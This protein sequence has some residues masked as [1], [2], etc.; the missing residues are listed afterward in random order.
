[1]QK[2]MTVGLLIFLLGLALIF[3]GA[4]TE[5]GFSAGGFILIGPFPIVFGAGPS[6]VTL[7][8][9]SIALGAAVLALVFLWSRR[10]FRGVS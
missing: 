6:G 3:L 5:G 4:A 7:A 2:L 8:I 9:L 1:M 10:I